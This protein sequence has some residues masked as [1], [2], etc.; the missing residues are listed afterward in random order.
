MNSKDN[1]PNCPIVPCNN[2]G[3]SHIP[4]FGKEDPHTPEYHLVQRHQVYRDTVKSS[5]KLPQIPPV[6][7]SLPCSTAFTFD[8]RTG[9]S[10]SRLGDFGSFF[11]FTPTESPLRT[12][13]RRSTPP[14]LDHTISNAQIETIFGS[15]SKSNPRSRPV[16]VPHLRSDEKLVKN[17]VVE[18]EPPKTVLSPVKVNQQQQP[19]KVSHAE[20]GTPSSLQSPLAKSIFNIPKPNHARPEHHRPAVSSVPASHMHTAALDTNK[21][22]VDPFQPRPSQKVPVQQPAVPRIHLDE[23][24][25]EIPRPA[26]ASTWS[27]YPVRQPIYSSN[28]DNRSYAS[29]G[30]LGASKTGALVDLTDTALFEDKFGAPDPYNYIDPE[31]ANENIKALLEGA[32]EDEDDKPKTRGRKKKLEAKTADLIDK[33][34]GLDMT[35]DGIHEE[36]EA[37]EEDEDEDDGTVEGLKVKLLPHQAEG[38]E[39][40]RQKE[41]SVKK[42]NGILP[43]GGIL[44]DDVGLHSFV[45]YLTRAD[46]SRWVLAKQS[47]L[48]LSFLRILARPLLLQRIQKIKS[49][50]FRIALARI[51][52]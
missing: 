30:R 21:G 16:L 17:M 9:S 33:L 10:L 49:T 42:K 40:M 11:S 32:F 44:A 24:V 28:M 48:L 45:Q 20:F 43:K 27:S 34:K 41:I 13:N 6:S 23:D 50:N 36:A 7:G 1:K 38:V 2:L 26:N 47:R 5:E 29:I 8:G 15:S 4:R 46:S 51:L 37:Q 3:S 35:P 31:K 14:Q 22:F 19:P 18:R 39:W 52:W 12:T 25:V